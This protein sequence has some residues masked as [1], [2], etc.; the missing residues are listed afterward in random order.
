MSQD[1]VARAEELLAR[2]EAAR[3]RLDATQDPEAAIEILQEL[4]TLARDVE[5]ELERAR[6][7]ADS[8]P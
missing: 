5:V 2:L 6:R 8:I 1:P 4:S 3:G 7:D